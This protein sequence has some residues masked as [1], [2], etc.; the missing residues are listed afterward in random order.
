MTIVSN[1]WSLKR[2]KFQN[3]F[4]FTKFFLI[5]SK[6]FIIKSMII[7][8][9][10]IR[11]S[12]NLICNDDDKRIADIEKHYCSSDLLETVTK[13][14][15]LN[16]TLIMVANNAI[17]SESIIGL[18]VRGQSASWPT[19]HRTPWTMEHYCAVLAT[20]LGSRGNLVSS[21]SSWQV[22]RQDFQHNVFQRYLH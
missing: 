2:K 12:C 16:L 18:R 20:Q 17:I 6:Y 9:E 14:L 10:K 8:L 22:K 21:T 3:K 5:F 19:R 1:G 13:P 7:I 15:I 11:N 4:F